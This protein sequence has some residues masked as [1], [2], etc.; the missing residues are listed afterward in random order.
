MKVQKEFSTLELEMKLIEDVDGTYLCTI[1]NSLYS[2]FSE[3]NIILNHG[4]PPN[5]FKSIQKYKE[6]LENAILVVEKKWRNYHGIV[7]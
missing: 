7:V 5:M 1:K 4:L 3:I 2:H 6:A